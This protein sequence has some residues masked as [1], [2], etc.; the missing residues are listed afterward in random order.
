MVRVVVYRSFSSFRSKGRRQASGKQH[1]RLNR[2][3]SP[4]RL[5]R[6][7]PSERARLWPPACFLEVGRVARC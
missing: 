2:P 1:S 7:L 3:S 5:L 6:L 4:S